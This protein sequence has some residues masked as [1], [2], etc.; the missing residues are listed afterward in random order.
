[1]RLVLS[2]GTII[3]GNPIPSKR[4]IKRKGGSLKRFHSRST[5]TSVGGTVNQMTATYKNFDTD[6]DDPS[7]VVIN[8]SCPEATCITVNSKSRKFTWE[9][10][11]SCSTGY[12]GGK[13]L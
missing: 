5:G 6:P 11:G 4:Q 8:R 10:G 13:G 1:V 12:I 7:V 9:V 3:E 2:D